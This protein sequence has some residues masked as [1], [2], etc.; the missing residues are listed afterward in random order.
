MAVREIVK[1]T[2][3]GSAPCC[4]LARLNNG[5]RTLLDLVCAACGSDADE[6]LMK[7]LGARNWRRLVDSWVVC[8]RLTGS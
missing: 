7:D 2:S 5:R 4:V 3:C 8:K 6:L 1:Y